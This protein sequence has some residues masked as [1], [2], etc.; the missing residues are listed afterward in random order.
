MKLAGLGRLGAG[1]K[2]LPERLLGSRVPP[3]AVERIDVDE[4]D[5]V[6]RAEGDALACRRARAIMNSVQ[7]GSAACE[8]ERPSGWLSSN[9]T[10]TTVSSSGVKPDEP[11]VAQIV[12]RAGLAGRVERKA[13][14]PHAV[15]GS[16]VDH[17]PHHVRDQERRL[18]PGDASRPVLV[19]LVT[20]WPPRV[21]VR[22]FESGRTV[23]ML[24]KMV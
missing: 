12:R 7:I 2:R 9:P 6:G 23:P 10:Q 1:D 20:S 18:G 5:A 19:L 15:A 8:P 16:F 13:G 11:G 4:A 14:R 17:A 21:T 22:M 24:G 3:A